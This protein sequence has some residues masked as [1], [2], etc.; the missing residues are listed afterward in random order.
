[1]RQIIEYM[2]ILKKIYKIYCNCKN[3]WYNICEL[4]KKG[5]IQK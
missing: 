5:V 2:I 1:M 3:M 4:E